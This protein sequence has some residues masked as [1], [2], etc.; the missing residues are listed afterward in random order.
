MQP[1]VSHDLP[2]PIAC[3]RQY[4]E[5]VDDADTPRKMLAAL[6]VMHRMTEEMLRSARPLEFPPMDFGDFLPPLPLP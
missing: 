6:D 4:T 5:P 1:A 2:T 3:L